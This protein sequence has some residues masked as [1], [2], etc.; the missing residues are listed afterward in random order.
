ML[1]FPLAFGFALGACERQR[2]PSEPDEG[3]THDVVQ[4]DANVPDRAGMDV[5][6]SDGKLSDAGTTDVMD[7]DAGPSDASPTL[8]VPAPD[9]TI[10]DA[11]ACM[12]VRAPTALGSEARV[13]T[14]PVWVAAETTGYA[15]TAAVLRSGAQNVWLHRVNAMGELTVEGDVTGASPGT[16]VRGGAFWP[17][18]EIYVLGYSTDAPGNLEVFVNRVQ[19]NAMSFPSPLRVTNDAES[20]EDAQVVSIGLAGFLVAWRSVSATGAR[21][22]ISRVDFGLTT[23]TAPALLSDPGAN[24]T[25]FRLVGDPSAGS[26]AVVFFDSRG[27]TTDIRLQALDT[28]GMRAGADVVVASGGDFGEGLDAVARGG[29]VVV[30]WT[31][32]RAAPTLRVRRMSIGTS[33]TGTSAPM[34]PAGVPGAASRPGIAI[35]GA[36]YVIGYRSGAGGT[37]ILALARLDADLRARDGALITGAG[38]GGRVGVA[39]RGDGTYGLA[40]ADDFSTGTATRL[41]VVRCP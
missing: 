4:R 3:L 24:V 10:G 19:S 39:S 29:D 28:N 18:G 5:P 34:E 16:E 32:T 21:L 26:W 36:G 38:P 35:D 15:A 17:E 27:A 41:V 22:M 8:D 6:E 14:R 30:A 13:F 1:V 33:G 20:S 2:P 9:V 25:E 12:M 23:A 11:G 7:M 31:Q 40:W 37:R